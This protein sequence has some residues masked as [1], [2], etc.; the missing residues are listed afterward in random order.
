M[1][2]KRILRH[3][4]TLMLASAI[5]YTSLPYISAEASASEVPQGTSA[6]KSGK[7]QRK[8]QTNKGASGAKSSSKKGGTSKKK[9]GSATVNRKKGASGRPETSADLKRRQADAQQEIKKTREELQRNEAEVKK[10]LSELS[11]LEGDIAVSRKETQT[12][13]AEVRKLDATI[14]TLTSKIAENSAELERLRSEYLKAVKKMRTSRKS[15]STLAYVFG[16]KN[17]AQAERRMRYLK[18]F[19]EWK[20][21][22]TKDINAKVALLKMEQEALQ[23]AK[24]DKDIML[25]RELKAQA[26][27][28]EQ[29][30]RQDAVVQ[31]L[32]A[33]G[34]ALQS[35]L[36]KKQ[37]EVNQ[38]RNRVAAL[39]AEEQRKAEAE[40]RAEEER[41]RKA[42]EKRLAAQRAEEERLEKERLQ[43]EAA[44]DADAAEREKSAKESVKSSKAE[45]HAA[46]KARKEA[47]K[48][49][50]E[51]RKQAERKEAA[52][53]KEAV[54]KKEAS[55]SSDKKSENKDYASARKRRPRGSDSNSGASGSSSA[56]S[57]KSTVQKNVGAD[58]ASMK[59]AL[60]R[61]VNGAFRIVSPFGRHALPDLPDVTYD[62]PGIDAEVSAGASAQAVY[63][64][65]VSGVYMIPGFSTVVIVNHGDYY[66]VYG[67]IAAASVKV[68]DRVSQGQKVGSLAEDPDSP[69]HSQIHFEVWKGRDKLNPASWI[70]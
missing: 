63:G 40:R 39:I 54:R 17:I 15:N 57:S 69:G 36:A 26:R 66:T 67:N 3:T 62:N 35:H 10:G 58:F 37:A 55:K 32:R 25:G 52:A 46:E 21:N 13:G 8:K 19:S 9:S 20:D 16:A 53:K 42:E 60:P 50:A 18:Q 14:G 22:R 56:S 68:G 30:Q 65:R 4:F 5:L 1:T 33:N 11:R 44:A 61:P 70:R 27:L 59:G 48:K 2:V 24:S 47:A 28:T 45:K 43:K 29:K 23:R 49:E 64:G 34:E 7:K 31:T 12:L 38:L 41:Q 51:S 6:L